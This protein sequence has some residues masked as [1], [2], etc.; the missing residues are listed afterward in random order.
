MYNLLCLTLRSNN[1]YH[2]SNANDFIGTTDMFTKLYEFSKISRA[3]GESPLKP[4]RPNGRQVAQLGNV[5]IK[6]TT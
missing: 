6:A 1:S 3:K 5:K 2:I 4:R